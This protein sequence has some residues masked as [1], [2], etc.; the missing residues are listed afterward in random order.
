LSLTYIYKKI[1]T[2]NNV[3][4]GEVQTSNHRA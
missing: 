1:L 4:S 2:T 3:T